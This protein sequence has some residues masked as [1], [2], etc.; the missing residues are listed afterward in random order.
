MKFLLLAVGGYLKT[1]LASIGG[2]VVFVA[3]GIWIYSG[4]IKATYLTALIN[5]INMLQGVANNAGVIKVNCFTAIINVSFV[6]LQGAF[7]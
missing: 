1:I 5:T 3:I 6:A 2:L 7:I 4:V